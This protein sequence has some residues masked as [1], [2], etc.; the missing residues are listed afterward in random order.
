MYVNS[1]MMATRAWGLEKI[2]EGVKVWKLL[3]IS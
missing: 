1:S 3:I 2:G